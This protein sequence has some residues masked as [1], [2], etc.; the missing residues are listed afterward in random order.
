MRQL[1]RAKARRDVE[2]HVLLYCA[3]VPRSLPSAATRLIQLSEA[4]ATVTDFDGAVCMP[5]RTSTLTLALC[6]SASR[7]RAK[8]AMWRSPS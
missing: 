2:P 6:S 5:A 4:S 3:S 7:L 8:V 1:A